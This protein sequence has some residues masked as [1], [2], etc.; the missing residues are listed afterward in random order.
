MPEDSIFIGNKPFLNYVSSITH[1]FNK[2][3][4]TEITVKAR[5]KFISKAVD[6]VEVAR[7]RFMKTPLEIKDIKIG[8]EAYTEK[9]SEGK[10]KRVN[11]STIDIT[12][13]K[14]T[15]EVNPNT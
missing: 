15:S 12:L 11:V 2:N 6:V 5:G 13:S 14:T 3:N 1:Q 10:E 9:N 7:R 4:R 8:T